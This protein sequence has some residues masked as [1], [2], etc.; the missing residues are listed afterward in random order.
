MSF[1]FFLAKVA[2]LVGTIYILGN[3]KFK[4]ALIMLIGQVIVVSVG[5]A[6]L[7]VPYFSESLDFDIGFLYKIMATIDSIG[8]VIFA[9]GFILMA[10][11]IKD[12]GGV[13]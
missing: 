8:M 5:F 3:K 4:N 9:A 2:V 1:L 7:I 6:Y 13:E 12:A 11:R 10:L